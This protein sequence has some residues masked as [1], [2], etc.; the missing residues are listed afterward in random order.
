MSNPNTPKQ[1]ILDD[2]SSLFDAVDEALADWHGEG[3]LQF[4]NLLMT[5]AVKLNW[6][7]TQVREYDPVI[8]IYVRRHPEWHVTRGAHGGI[9]R[10]SEKAK[11]EELKAAKERAKAE[12]KAALEAK[13]AAPAVVSTAGTD[14]TNTAS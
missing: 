9:M 10:A 11:K 6:N 4:P 3:C 13:A 14:N 12:I 8:R 5:L 7:D 2:F 1:S